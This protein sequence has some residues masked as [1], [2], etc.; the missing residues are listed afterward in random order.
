MKTPSPFLTALTVTIACLSAGPSATAQQRTDKQILSEYLAIATPTLDPSRRSDKAYMAEYTRLGKAALQRRCDLILELYRLNPQH[1]LIADLMPD[2][3]SML[4]RR[5]RTQ[6]V[7]TALVDELHGVMADQ[8]GSGLAQ[9]AAHAKTQALIA[10]TFFDQDPAPKLRKRREGDIRAAVLD[11]VE[12]YPK[13]PRCAQTLLTVAQKYTSDLELRRSLYQRCATS[14]PND[15]WGRYA[16]GKLRQIEQVGK[17]FVLAFVDAISGKAASV[18]Q[19][20]GRVIVIDFW[21]T[22]CVPCLR[23]MPG[24][25]Q[26]YAKYHGKGVEFIGVS[27]DDPPEKGGLQKLREYVKK[28]EIG[29]PQYYQGN[30]FES[31]FSVSWGVNS[32]PALFLIDADGKLYSTNARSDL[33]TLIPKLLARR[34]AKDRDGG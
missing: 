34:A 30:R 11:F 26:L 33:Q 22:W 7:L 8:P 12:R 6:P 21:A 9:D 20:K 3:W 32:I 19:F 2:R 10:M 29:W 25:K 5:L 15:K 13:D 27:L 28:N 14:Y 17:P 23:E 24:M 16:V 4:A 18:E 31:A 1:E